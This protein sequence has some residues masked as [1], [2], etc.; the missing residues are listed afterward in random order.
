MYNKTITLANKYS[1]IEGSEKKNKNLP[2]LC[3]HSEIPIFID[4]FANQIMW[5]AYVIPLCIVIVDPYFSSIKYFFFVDSV[6]V[7]IT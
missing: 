2:Y 1:S 4:N 6:P 3:C 5:R 7:L